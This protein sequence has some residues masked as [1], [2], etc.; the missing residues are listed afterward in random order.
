MIFFLFIYLICIIFDKID[1]DKKISIRGRISKG[2]VMRCSSGLV[3]P[4]P[5]AVWTR[6]EMTKMVDLI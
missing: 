2:V 1:I 4:R 3:A 6:G 5:D